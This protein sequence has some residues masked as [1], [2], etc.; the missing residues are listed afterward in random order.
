MVDV[1]KYIQSF[2]I[3]STSD[4]SPGVILANMGELRWWR[5]GKRAVTLRSWYALPR[6]S[7]VELPYKFDPIKNTIPGNRSTDEHVAYIFN[8]VVEQLVAPTAQ[9]D[10]IGVSEGAVRVTGFLDDE[11]NWKKWSER[12]EAFAAVATYTHADE[13]KN[14]SFADWFRDVGLP[15]TSLYILD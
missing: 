4:D 10:V 13:I 6:K 3:S 14:K 8:N 12:I 9:L 5:R 7:A 11:T 1:V 2:K 15:S